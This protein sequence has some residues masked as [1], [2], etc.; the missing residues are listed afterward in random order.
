[1]KKYTAEEEERLTV[2][3]PTPMPESHALLEVTA[4]KNGWPM[5]SADIV[6]AF[7]IGKDRGDVNGDPVFM[8]APSEWA[9]IYYEWLETLS[10]ES[11]SFYKDRFKDRHRLQG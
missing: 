11:K 2:S 9:E 5:M 7:L 10:P 3:T 8:D 4:L 1:M 6:A